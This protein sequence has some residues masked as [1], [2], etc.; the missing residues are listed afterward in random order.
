MGDTKGGPF[1][2]EI[3]IEARSRA[4]VEK[5]AQS[6]A[7]LS[8][9]LP[10]VEFRL[11]PE[12]GQTRVYARTETGLDDAVKRL[13]QEIRIA[14]G[15]PQIAY[16]EAPSHAAEVDY[17]HKK[18]LGPTGQFA[19]VQL[20]IEPAEEFDP[21]FVNADV[22]GAVLA[23]YIPGVERG[24][25]SIFSSGPLVGFPMI[26]T[27]VELV[28]GA[29]HD[30]DSSPLAFEIAAR[31]AMRDAADRLGMRLFEPVMHLE[32]TAPE[33]FAGTVIGALNSCRG[34]IR[35][36]DTSGET[37]RIEAL[38]PLANL[39]GYRQNLAETTMDRATLTMAFDHY[40]PVPNKPP[41]D[42]FP[43]AMAMRA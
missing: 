38:A 9:Q 32:V 14:V 36:Q 6:I 22:G 23:E 35:T 27:R 34:E 29:Y 12:S 31:A 4:D 2:L 43:G 10:A 21:S 18:I 11:D 24:V 13:A 19:R 1:L 5:L 42:I 25:R 3:A 40:R 39:F 15:A 30:V 37:I 33:E 41:D 20:R 26:R 7:A 8:E 16:R 28:D 17:T